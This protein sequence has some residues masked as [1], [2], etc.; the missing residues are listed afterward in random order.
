MSLQQ[1]VANPNWRSHVTMDILVNGYLQQE[2]AEEIKHQYPGWSYAAYP[3]W[4]ESGT[5]VGKRWNF[6][7]Q[8]HQTSFVGIL[9]D[10]ETGGYFTAESW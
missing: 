7:V 8:N 4:G 2:I 6:D 3:D 9:H 5:E 10:M 1:Q